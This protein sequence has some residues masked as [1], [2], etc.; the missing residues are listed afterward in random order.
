MARRWR[1][2]AGEIDIIASRRKLLIFVEVKARYSFDD[3]AW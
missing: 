1:S 3:A 2:P